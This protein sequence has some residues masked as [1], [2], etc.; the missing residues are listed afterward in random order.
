MRLSSQHIVV[1]ISRV[2]GR[3]GEEGK[4]GCVCT[5]KYTPTL[6]LHQRGG[7]LIASELS[8]EVLAA[9]YTLLVKRRHTRVGAEVESALCAVDRKS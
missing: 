4:G 2:S 5:V 7:V 8:D 3:A 9:E 6:L 1:E